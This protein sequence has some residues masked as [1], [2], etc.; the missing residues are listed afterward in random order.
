MSSYRLSLTFLP[1]ITD[2]FRRNNSFGMPAIAQTERFSHYFGQFAKLTQ[3]L[4]IYRL[5]LT[6]ERVIHSPSNP[7]R[8]SLTFLPAIADVFNRL[9]LT[10]KS[11]YH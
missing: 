10:R 6:L 9:S 1:A 11:G 5:S 8:L 2:V 7:Y 3:V 4:S